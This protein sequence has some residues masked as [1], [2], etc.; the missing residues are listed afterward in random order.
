MSA[1]V[2]LPTTARARVKQVSDGYFDT[3]T[4]AT[5]DLLTRER[6]TDRVWEPA[7]GRGM[8]S[9][10]LML[11]G[12][13][14]ISTDL[15]DRGHGTGGVDFLLERTLLA[16]SIVTNP[17]FSLANEFALHALDTLRAEK[18]AMFLRLAFLEGQERH[19]I[20]WRE[21]PPVRVLVFS[22]R[23]TLWR[24]DDPKPKDKGGA[25]AYAWFVWER[26]FRGAPSLGWIA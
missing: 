6:F 24:G 2:T 10:P 4:S 26:G 14:V 19:K 11:A 7:C 8:I 17:P 22:R 9:E 3:P 23:L 16:P 5:N 15:V 20:L 13:E 18:L 12:Y 25:I 21:F 1:Y